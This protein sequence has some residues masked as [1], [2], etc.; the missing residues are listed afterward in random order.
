MAGRSADLDLF[1][2]EILVST[3][4]N[5]VAVTAQHWIAQTGASLD[6]ESRAIWNELLDRLISVVRAGYTA[7]S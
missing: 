5:G 2:V 6:A 1:E 3:L 7:P 4:M